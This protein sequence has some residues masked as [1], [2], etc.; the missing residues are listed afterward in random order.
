MTNR[1][2]ITPLDRPRARPQTRPLDPSIGECATTI[3]RAL[4]AV[5]R[6]A[7]NG[8][9]AAVRM[10]ADLDRDLDERVWRAAVAVHRSGV[11]MHTIATAARLTPQAAG[12][13]FGPV[14]QQRHAQDIPHGWLVPNPLAGIGRTERPPR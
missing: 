2:T 13:R 3:S 4:S 8:N 10:L 14:A 11:D 6:H 12:R 9:V 7:L 5:E 1:D